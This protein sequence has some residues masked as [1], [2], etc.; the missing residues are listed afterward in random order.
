VAVD[1]GPVTAR[2]AV[3]AGLV[4]AGVALALVPP[5]RASQR[6]RRLRRAGPAPRSLVLATYD[7]FTDRAAELGHPRAP[8]QTLEEYRR[9]V[10][11][12]ARLGGDDL[13]RLTAVATLAAYGGGDL[14]RD[15]AETVRSASDSVV[16]AMRRE[17]GWT[18]RLTGPYRRR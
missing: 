15:D 13:D 11:G 9:A 16:R 10:A 12:G 4:A 14:D 8:G 17:A 7:V 5:V 2:N 6:R 18:Q 3:L 1:P